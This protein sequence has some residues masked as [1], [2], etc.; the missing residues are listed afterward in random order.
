MAQSS[1]TGGWYMYFGNAAWANSAWS[2]H[3]EGQY[4]NH[5]LAG[6]LEQ[7][8]LRSG[9]QYNLK[10]RS[11]TFTAGYGYIATQPPGDDNTTVAENRLY[12]EA[13]LRQTIGRV[14]LLH[15]FRYEQRF[16]E[17]QAFRTRYRYALFL[18]IPL[19][20]SGMA[21]KTWYIGLYNEVFVNGKKRANLPVFDRDRIY[22]ALGYMLFDNLG[23]QAGYMRQV[24]ERSSKGQIQLSLHHNF[25]L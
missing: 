11:A 2:L 25:T 5:N 13:L 6:D 23:L 8:L 3:L 7:L 16:I 20:S 9:A 1:R 17:N 22:G 12:Q 24:Y 18:N 21:A 19:N 14:R 10:D 4:R 15:R